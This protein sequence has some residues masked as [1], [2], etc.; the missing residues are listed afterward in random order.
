MQGRSHLFLD[1]GAPS[2]AKRQMEQFVARVRRREAPPIEQW[3]G[4]GGAAPGGGLGAKPPCNGG[5]GGGKAPRKFFGV[6]G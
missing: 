6:F 5:L 3:Q 2:G 4:A 1:G